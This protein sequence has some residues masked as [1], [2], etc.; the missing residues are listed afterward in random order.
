MDAE[1]FDADENF[2]DAAFFIG[3]EFTKPLSFDGLP[4]ANPAAERIGDAAAAR[5]DAA[6]ETGVALGKIVAKEV[7]IGILFL[8]TKQF[9]AR[10]E[11]QIN[12]EQNQR[13][14]GWDESEIGLVYSNTNTMPR[15]TS[16]KATNMPARLTVRMA[17]R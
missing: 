1:L 7:V 8:C 11:V 12:R 5:G 16:A 9:L 14:P 3:F 13:Q 10:A 2:V 17:A 4:L 6:F 15:G